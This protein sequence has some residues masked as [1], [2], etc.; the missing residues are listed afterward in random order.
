MGTIHLNVS[1]H[2]AHVVIDDEAHHNAMTLEMWQKLHSTF[3]QINEQD[4]IRVVV[5]RGAGEKSFVSG[6]NIRE[7]DQLR[8][9]SAAVTHY[10]QCVAAAQDGIYRCRVPVVVAISG[11][12]FGGGLGLALCGDL[13]IAASGTRFRMPAARLGLGYEFEGMKSIVRNMGY[14]AA[15]EAFYTARIYQASDALRL[16]IV[17]EVCDRVF[18]HAQ[19]VA[20]EIASNAPLTIRAAKMALRAIADGSREASPEIRQAV[21]ACFAS[22]D[23]AEG[24]LAFAQKRAPVFKGQ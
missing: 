18:D 7:F 10:N 17:N 16:G 6:A 14:L 15:S 24:R 4:S 12:C 13:R 21:D 2:I 8:S 11:L 23:Y 5:L 3:L 22:S 1:Q 9:S 19:E 20:N